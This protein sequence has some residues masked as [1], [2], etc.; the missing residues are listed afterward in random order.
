[1]AVKVVLVDVN[2]AMVEAWR[3]SFADHPEVEVV[4][5]SMLEQRVG[6][7]VS[8]T[9]GLGVMDGGLDG[10]IK[11][12]FGAAIEKRVQAEIAREPG[13][14]LAVGRAVCVPTGR[15]QP[16]CLISAPT[17]AA[18]SEGIGNTLNPAFACGAA[19]QAAAMQN[20]REPNS[21]PSLALPGLGAATGGVPVDTCADLMRVAYELLQEERFDTFEDMRAALEARLE[22]V[23]PLMGIT[24]PSAQPHEDDLDD[25]EVE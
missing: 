5:G 12:H 11:K 14:V 7:W 6:A 24:P 17:M 18:Q 13:G 16:R 19:L 10:V 21:V 22:D 2:E 4:H 23:A 1:M 8:P 25:E 3:S 20:A 15:D 9:N